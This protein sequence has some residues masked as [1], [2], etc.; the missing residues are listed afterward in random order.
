MLSERMSE[1]PYWTIEVVKIAYLC[2]LS[3]AQA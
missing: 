2:R 1:S 3:K